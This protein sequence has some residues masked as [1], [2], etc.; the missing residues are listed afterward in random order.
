MTS[1]LVCRCVSMAS[2]T[3]LAD[4]RWRE[5]GRIDLM[6]TST[7]VTLFRGGRMSCV[8]FTTT[9]LQRHMRANR[10][11]TTSELHFRMNRNVRLRYLSSSSSVLNSLKTPLHSTRVWNVNIS[12]DMSL[13]KRLALLSIILPFLNTLRLCHRW[14]TL[15]PPAPTRTAVYAV[16]QRVLMLSSDIQHH[17]EL[18]FCSTSREVGLYAYCGWEVQTLVS[19]YI[20][21]TDVQHHFETC[22]TNETLVYHQ[23]MR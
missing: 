15:P 13:W 17:W 8:C 11:T 2:A 16:E 19:C 4:R 6:T 20:L 21:F 10:F 18:R 22:R 14:Q 9:I 3:S 23:I 5:D 12:L 1:S 7:S